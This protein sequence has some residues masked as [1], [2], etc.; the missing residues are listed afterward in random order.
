[1][2]T[3]KT[4]LVGDSSLENVMCVQEEMHSAEKS[5]MCIGWNNTMRHSCNITT[6]V[7]IATTKLISFASDKAKLVTST[8]PIII[9]TT[10]SPYRCVSE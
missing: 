4:V 1:M 3:S 5:E 7:T 9:M 10:K 6:G 2:M 8:I